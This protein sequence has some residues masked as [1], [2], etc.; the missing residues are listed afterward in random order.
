MICIE[1]FSLPSS[2]SGNC[3]L[4]VCYLNYY[5]RRKKLI[6]PFFSFSL[7]VW[8]EI[9]GGGKWL[10][11]KIDDCVCINLLCFIKIACE[12]TSFIH[13][14]LF[15]HTPTHTSTHSDTISLFCHHLLHL[16]FCW[17]ANDE[18]SS[19]IYIY[20]QTE[21]NNKTRKTEQQKGKE[22]ESKESIMRNNIVQSVR[23]IVLFNKIE[24]RN[25]KKTKKT[26]SNKRE[27]VKKDTLC[28]SPCCC[29]C[30]FVCAFG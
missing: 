9:K 2:V 20:K 11:Q 30:V 19:W 6:L 14:L 22:S 24:M 4:C 7:F 5:L 1:L 12:I 18:Q 8:C 26:N 13:F 10:I 29:C 16:R 17:W 27:H 3:F 23:N 15:S 28:L 25:Q 21:P